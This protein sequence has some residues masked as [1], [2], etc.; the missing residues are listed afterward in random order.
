MA[1][2]WLTPLGYMEH[3]GRQERKG[4]GAIAPSLV[5]PLRSPLPSLGV[6]REAPA[7]GKGAPTGNAH[8]AN[9]HPKPP[10]PPADHAQKRPGKRA[11][12][13]PPGPWAAGKPPTDATSGPHHAAPGP[14]PGPNHSIAA[15]EGRPN[16]HPRPAEG[17]HGSRTQTQHE[18][19]RNGGFGGRVP[20]RR[21]NSPRPHEPA[22]PPPTER[23]IRGQA[24]GASEAQARRMACAG[25]PRSPADA[26]GKGQAHGVPPA[27]ACGKGGGVPGGEGASGI[28]IRHP[29]E[30]YRTDARRYRLRQSR[31]RRKPVAPVDR[32]QGR[33]P[34]AAAFPPT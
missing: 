9:P 18:R 17:P 27:G 5:L 29:G 25:E 16:Q 31:Y 19:G 1:G 30:G 7:H 11:R 24:A 10:Q 20:A 15:G 8:G 28:A 33:S 2:G 23:A 26:C 12:E 3:P 6:F 4:E 21:A 13:G 32:G 14:S 22:K 34:A